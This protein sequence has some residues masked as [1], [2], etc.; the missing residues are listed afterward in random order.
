MNK[1]VKLKEQFLLALSRLKEVM[2]MEENDI[3]RDSAIQR[4]E[5][6]L[7]LALRYLKTLLEESK[8]VICNSPKDCFREAFK[9]SLVEYDDFWIEMVDLRNQTSHTY[10]EE[11]AIKVYSNLT[12]SIEF[13]TKLKSL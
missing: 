13:F 1:L 4:F 3:V 11:I 10:R 2:D 5:F 9:Q 6:T 7:D 8:G 12:K